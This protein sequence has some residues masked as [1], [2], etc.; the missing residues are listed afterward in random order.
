MNDFMSKIN[1]YTSFDFT[2]RLIEIEMNGFIELNE[3]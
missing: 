2:K 3:M 1:V